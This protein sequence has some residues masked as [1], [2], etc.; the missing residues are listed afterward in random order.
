MKSSAFAGAVAAKAL[1]DSLA[2]TSNGRQIQ[3]ALLDDTIFM[4]NKTAHFNNLLLRLPENS[5]GCVCRVGY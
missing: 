3:D 1:V 4:R 5:V 2:S